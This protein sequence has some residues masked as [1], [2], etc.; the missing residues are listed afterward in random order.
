M[1]YQGASIAKHRPDFIVQ[2]VVVLELKAVKQLEPGAAA[3]MLTYLRASGLR[4]GLVVNF[5][6]PII[7]LGVKRFVL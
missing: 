2:G 4:V 3:Q 6:A 1:K 7:S 5:N